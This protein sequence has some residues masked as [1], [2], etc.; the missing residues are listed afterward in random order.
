MKEIS[1]HPLRNKHCDSVNLGLSSF[2]QQLGKKRH[3]NDPAFAE[4]WGSVSGH[5]RNLT[6]WRG[7]KVKTRYHTE[8]FEKKKKKMECFSR[9]FL[10][11]A[12][13]PFSLVYSTYLLL[14]RGFNTFY[15]WKDFCGG[16]FFLCLCLFSVCDPCLAFIEFCNR[17]LDKRNFWPIAN[18]YS[19]DYCGS[20]SRPLCPWILNTLEHLLEVHNSVF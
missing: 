1:R 7:T 12:Y 6:R 2:G 3:S 18:K 10:F 5:W 13:S 15:L 9:I 14:S 19:L 17:L 11:H 8:K 20:F 16:S 4:N